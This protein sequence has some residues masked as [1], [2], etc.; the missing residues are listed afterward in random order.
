M[1]K[2]IQNQLKKTFV[3]GLPK[4][5][6]ENMAKNSYQPAS[7]SNEN[8]SLKDYFFG[9]PMFF[10]TNCELFHMQLQYK[11]EKVHGLFGLN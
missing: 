1:H 10:S 8:M 11:S 7:F 3:I 6:I 5:T 4:F 9:S 2:A